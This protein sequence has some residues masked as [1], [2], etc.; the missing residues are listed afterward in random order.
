VADVF[1]VH[2]LGGAKVAPGPRYVEIHDALVRVI[3]G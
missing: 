2:E 3:D 1:Y